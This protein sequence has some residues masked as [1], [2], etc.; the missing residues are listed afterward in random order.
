MSNPSTLFPASFEEIPGW[1]ERAGRTTQEARLRFAQY[2]ILYALARSRT[3]RSL[4]VFK[5][6]NA[7]DFIWSSNRS[8]RD[9]DFSVE[10]GHFDEE[11][12]V[13]FLP[14]ALDRSRRDLGVTYRV[15]K[16]ERQPPGPD[17]TFVTIQVRVGYALPDD[18]P[19]RQRI[20]KEQPSPLVVPLDISLNEAVCDWTDVQLA[21]GVMVRVCTAEDIAAE[22]LRALLQ[23]PIRNRHR[24]Q[25]LL[26]LVVM[27]RGGVELKPDSVARFLLEKAEARNVPVSRQ[28]F[29]EPELITRTGLNYDDLRSTAHE[30]FVPFEEAM[31]EL[32]AF[33][34]SLPIP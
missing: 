13:E 15:Q 23:Q 6:G 32:Q 7:L 2:G 22:K 33:V 12:V 3:L 31:A 8:T 27:L 16:V 26:D 1:A 11:S 18:A 20:E 19:A 29:R 4:L 30:T 14:N 5:G 25:D 9:L 17:K 24:S 10:G 21:D 34:D 28:A